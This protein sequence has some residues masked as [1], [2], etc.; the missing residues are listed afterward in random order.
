MTKYQTKKNK[1]QQRCQILEQHLS[2]RTNVKMFETNKQPKI[3][4]QKK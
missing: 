4:K 1:Q 3:K 2:F